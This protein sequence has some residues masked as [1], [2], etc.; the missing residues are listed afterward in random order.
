MRLYIVLFSF[1]VIISSCKESFN[2]KLDEVN[3]PLVVDGLITDQAQPY[4]IKLYKAAK[5]NSDQTYTQETNA[6]VKVSDDCGNTYNFTETSAGIYVSNPSQFVGQPGRTYILTINTND[7]ILYHSNPQLL[8]PNNFNV[9]AYAEFGTKDQLVED[10]DGNPS[11]QS[12]QGINLLVDI[13]NNTDTLARFRFENKTSLEYSYAVAISLWKT[14]IYFCW[15]LQNDNSLVNISGEQYQTSSNDIKKHK[16]CFIP[17]PEAIRANYSDTVEMDPFYTMAYVSQ[18]I[19]KVSQFRINSE[20]YQF[21]KDVNTMLAAQSKM[22]DPGSTQIKGNVH[23][24]SNPQKLVLGLFE[25]SSVTT[26]YYAIKPGTTKVT[27]IIKFEPP[28]SSGC[29]GFTSPPFLS[30]PDFW[31][32]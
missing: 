11:K 6:D 18:Q 29:L 14:Y 3:S 25:A 20:T 19:I 13:Q 16:I 15:N 12:L 1:V 30:P 7:N 26:N 27:R 23:C 21:N 22:F 4:T 28:Y 9:T 32:N 2:P 24:D 10:A 8:L 17:K 5:F 31:V